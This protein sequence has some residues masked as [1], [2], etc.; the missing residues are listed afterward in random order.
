MRGNRPARPAAWIMVV[1]LIAAIR[2][3]LQ[4]ILITAVAIAVFIV[5]MVLLPKVKPE[6]N[7]PAPAANA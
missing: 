7:K 2:P 5:A 6:E 4:G 3:G 1:T